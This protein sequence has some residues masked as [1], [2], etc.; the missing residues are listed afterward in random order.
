MIR[1]PEIKLRE[2]HGIT[3]YIELKHII[4]IRNKYNIILSREELNKRHNI[5]QY[6]KQ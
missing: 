6:N 4:S 2:K 5:K 3:Y 1:I